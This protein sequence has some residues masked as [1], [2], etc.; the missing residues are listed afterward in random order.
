VVV[1]LDLNGLV[2]CQPAYYGR[3]WHADNLVLCPG[4]AP[5]LTRA[6][7]MSPLSNTMYPSLC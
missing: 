7:R 1:A 6:R 2:G 3:L 4:Q 5:S